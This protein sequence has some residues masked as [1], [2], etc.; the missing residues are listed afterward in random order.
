[1]YLAITNSKFTKFGANMP[2]Q[3][4]KNKMNGH[5]SLSL[6]TVD[7]PVVIIDYLHRLPL[8]PSGQTIQIASDHTEADND[9]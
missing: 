1:M 3:D 2:Y 8:L 5:E 7:S 4:D 6:T 9:E